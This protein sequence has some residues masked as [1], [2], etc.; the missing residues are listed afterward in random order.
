MAKTYATITDD[1]DDA[2]LRRPHI[3][4]GTE[5]EIPNNKLKWD[6][7]NPTGRGIVF[8]NK[9][10]YAAAIIDNKSHFVFQSSSLRSK[11]TLFP[12]LS[13]R[14]KLSVSMSRSNSSTTTAPSIAGCIS[15]MKNETR[16]PSA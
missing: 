14:S 2:P 12:I 5:I 15:A 7:S 8:V 16:L 1:R 11:N 9:S 10:G 6:K 3:D 4:I 13:H